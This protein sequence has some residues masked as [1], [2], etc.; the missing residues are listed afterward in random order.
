MPAFTAAFSVLYAGVAKS[1]RTYALERDTGAL[2]LRGDIEVRAEIHYVAMHP[3]R[4]HLYIAAS[5][6]AQVHLI[7]AFAID[8]ATGVLTRVG[9]PFSLPATLS[10]AIHITVDRTGRYLLTANNLTESVGVLRLGAGG[11]LDALIA[12]PALA[13]LGFLP[14]Q[15]RIDPAN[16][17]V[18]V[19]VRGNDGTPE[20]IGRLH[21]FSFTDG[22][23]HLQRTI[24]YEAGIGP[25]HLDFHPTRPWVYL[26]AERGNQLITYEHH[27]GT[28]RELFRTTTLRDPSL[29]FPAQRA[30]AIHVHPDGRWI[31]ATNRNVEG[32]ENTVA[33]FSVDMTSG[34]PALVEHVDSRGFEPRTFTIDPTG[35]FLVAANMMTVSG[36]P[37]NLAV[38]R[39]GPAGDLTFERSYDQPQ[40]GVV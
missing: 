26:L 5:D 31:Y 6:R 13:K 10:R 35:S 7:Y 11:Q 9:E 37:P 38:F 25:R 15:I 1:L 3:D 36:V 27:A 32:G 4:R 12:G 19:P 39:I 24:D 8:A 2:E 16:Q 33:L 22:V 20:Q 29:S 34:K 30:G 40:G 28:L 17:W 18:F 23:L 14:H 21:V